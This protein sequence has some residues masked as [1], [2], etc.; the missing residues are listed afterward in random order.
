M[1]TLSIERERRAER[2]LFCSFGGSLIVECTCQ[3]RYLRVVGALLGGAQKD[4]PKT[5]NRALGAPMGEGM[6]CPNGTQ[7][8]RY[9]TYLMTYM[10]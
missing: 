10:K 6:L 5:P 2:D 3:R 7:L 8:G 9:D 4:P 1:N